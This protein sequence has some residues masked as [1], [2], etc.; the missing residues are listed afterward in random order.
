MSGVDGD[1]CNSCLL[2]YNSKD[3]LPK[4]LSCYHTYCRA[5]L[6][7]YMFRDR[8]ITCL[9]CSKITE[10]ESVASLPE[11]PY[12]RP[13]PSTEEEV[14][15]SDS[16][17]DDDSTST[18]APRQENGGATKGDHVQGIKDMVINTQR[19]NIHRIQSSL[20]FS[21]RR[22]QAA[23][24]VRGQKEQTLKDAIKAVDQFKFKLEGEFKNNQSQVNQLATQEATAKALKSTLDTIDPMDYKTVKSIFDETNRIKKSLKVEVNSSRHH[25]LEQSIRSTT[26]K[27]NFDKSNEMLSSLKA[28]NDTI[29]MKV[30]LF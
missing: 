20:D 25:D 30:S 17:D 16:D 28:D 27:I 18:P 22:L 21:L 29:Y 9:S 24:G 23:R 26:V 19:T 1:T 7:Q 6:Q 15:F 8:K 5:C 11:N 14:Y 12:L 4:I 10:A 2:P 13:A 3:R